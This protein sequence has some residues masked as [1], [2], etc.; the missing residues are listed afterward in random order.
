MP[1]PALAPQPLALHA[2]FPPTVL[3]TSVA[4]PKFSMPPPYPMQEPL[5]LQAVLSATVLLLRVMGAGM[6]FPVQGLKMPPPYPVQEPLQARLSLTVLAFSV[7]VPALEMPPPSPRLQ[8]LPLQATFSLTVLLVRIIVPP[9][10][11]AAARQ[12]I[13]TA[14]PE[15]QDG[16][17]PLVVRIISTSRAAR[18]SGRTVGEAY[19]ANTVG[20]IAG[21]FASGFIL[22]PFL[23]LLGSL[24]LCAALNF[25][26]AAAL[27]FV[28]PNQAKDAAARRRGD[29][30]KSKQ[31]DGRFKGL[32]L[33][34]ARWAGVAVSALCVIGIVLLEPAWDSQVMSSAVYRYA[35]QLS[36]KSKSEVF[37]Y[38][39]R[40]QGD[41]IFYK[42]G[43]TATVASS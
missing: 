19:A 38:L 7:K 5:V 29:A 13:E 27:F 14:W 21:S 22:I 41:S 33:T 35:P 15:L 32:G 2:A 10:E 42:E 37:D 11:K 25:V 8:A 20:A 17:L 28:L 26:V 39:R 1:P 31:S 3:L 23:G 36:N 12:S 16:G 34:S 24:R 40:G 4:V 30:G 6:Q 9:A 43:I 18:R